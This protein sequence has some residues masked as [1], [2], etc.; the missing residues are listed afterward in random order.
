MTPE[1]QK[2][3]LAQLSGAPGPTFPDYLNSLDACATLPRTR[4][5]IW[6]RVVQRVL[7]PDKAVRRA[8]HMSEAE[9]FAIAHMTPAQHCEV[10]LRT[11]YKWE[12]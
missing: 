12:E 1:R 6:L 4:K 9:L 2:I 3:A 5:E 8:Q 11:H 7:F 10:T